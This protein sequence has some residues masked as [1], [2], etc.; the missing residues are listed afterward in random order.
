[1]SA[2]SQEISWGLNPF[3]ESW[4]T[5]IIY[6]FIYWMQCSIFCCTFLSLIFLPSTHPRAR[7]SIKHKTLT[8]I[9]PLVFITS[10]VFLLQR[11]WEISILGDTLKDTCLNSDSCP[12]R[13]QSLRTESVKYTKNSRK[14]TKRFLAGY[15][16]FSFLS[17]Q[18]FIFFYF[19]FLYDYLTTAILQGSSAGSRRAEFLG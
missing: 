16:V 6:L 18:F 15:W 14:C 9:F 12:I 4:I 1:M 10:C 11:N 3:E 13:T 5:Y 7:A 8:R 17:F 2:L 19:L